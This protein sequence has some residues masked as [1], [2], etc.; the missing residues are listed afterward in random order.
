MNK[1][2]T[3]IRNYISQQEIRLMIVYS[4]LFIGLF[5]NIEYVL[6]TFSSEET[7]LELISYSFNIPVLPTVI[8]SFFLFSCADVY[9]KELKIFYT[10]R[11][12]NR[13]QLQKN[14]TNNLFFSSVVF[15]AIAFVFNSVISISMNG[16]SDGFLSIYTLIWFSVNFLFLV[17]CFFIVGLMVTILGLLIRNIFI[18][19]IFC[20]SIAIVDT[21]SSIS[22]VYKQALINVMYIAEP[23]KMSYTFLYIYPT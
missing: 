2:N 13:K 6:Y 7:T 1:Y 12:S 21:Y 16:L 19:V 14:I 8:S 11:L 22:L 10:I 9:L 5:C 15:V 18:A 17:V 20:I 4:L 3:L 23:L